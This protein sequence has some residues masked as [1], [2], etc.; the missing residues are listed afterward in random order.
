MKSG[1]TD[2]EG[3]EAPVKKGG[4]VRKIDGKKGTKKGKEEKETFPSP[5]KFLP[6][7]GSCY[8]KRGRGGREKKRKRKYRRRGKGCTRR[9]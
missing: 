6:A 2:Q 1:T 4:E 9:R 5:I 8:K 3:C 7:R